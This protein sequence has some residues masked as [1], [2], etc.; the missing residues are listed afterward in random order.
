MAR[1]VVAISVLTLC[2]LV[3]VFGLTMAAAYELNEHCTDQMAWD[4]NC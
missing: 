3:T 2:A 1:T 4:G